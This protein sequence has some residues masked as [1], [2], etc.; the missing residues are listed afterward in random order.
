MKKGQ[1]FLVALASAG[2]TFGILFG[3]LGSTEF[4]KCGKQR[5][6]HCMHQAPTCAEADQK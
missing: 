3:S 4:N 6:A 2:L 5:H 1:R